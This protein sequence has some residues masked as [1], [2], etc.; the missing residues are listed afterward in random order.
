M[1]V[2]LTKKNTPMGE[3][4]G[5]VFRNT[6]LFEFT[7]QYQLGLPQELIELIRLADSLFVNLSFVNFAILPPRFKKTPYMQLFI[8]HD[9]LSKHS[10]FLKE[11]RKDPTL[12]LH[13]SIVENSIR[14]VEMWIKY[15]PEW[16]TPAP[17][18][19]AAICGHLDIVKRL[20]VASKHVWTPEAMNFAAMNGHLDV[21]MWLHN[22]KDGPGCTKTAMDGAA[23]Y[24]HLEVVQYLNENRSE[25]CT[26]NALSYAIFYGY[27]KVVE[28]LLSNGHS[29]VSGYLL[30]SQHHSAHYDKLFLHC[31]K[32]EK[33]YLG[34]IKSLH[35]HSNPKVY[36]KILFKAIK[37]D[38]VQTLQFIHEYRVYGI[39]KNVFDK[40][41]ESADKDA[42]RYALECI[43]SENNKPNLLLD[44]ANIAVNPWIPFDH[45]WF[46]EKEWNTTTAMDVAAA[47]GDLDSVILLHR[48]GIKC[49]T[50]EAMDKAAG[51]GRLDIVQ[52]LHK[53]RKESCSNDAMTF[54]A[55][56]GHLDVV[57][58]L[59][60]VRG[61]N[62]TKDG[63]CSAATNGDATMVSYLISITMSFE[64]NENFGFSGGRCIK[65]PGE[66]PIIYVTTGHPLHCAASRGHIKVVEIL[67]DYPATTF[68][69]N[70]AAHNGHLEMVDYLHTHRDEGCSVQAYEIAIQQNRLEIL[71]YLVTNKCSHEPIDY[72]ML[73]IEAAG[74]KNL[75]MFIFCMEQLQTNLSPLSKQL[76]MQKASTRGSLDMVKWLY[77]TK[78][79]KWTIKIR[80]AAQTQNHTIQLPMIL[81]FSASWSKQANERI[82]H[83]LYDIIHKHANV[84]CLF[85]SAELDQVRFTEHVE[86]IAGWSEVFPYNKHDELAAIYRYF[87]VDSIPQIRIIDKN[88]APIEP[89][90]LIQCSHEGIAILEQ[91]MAPNKSNVNTDVDE[92]L[93]HEMRRN[94]NIM[95][96]EGDF[97]GAAVIFSE[98]LAINPNCIKSNFN[99]AVILHTM[100]QTH[101]AVKLMFKVVENDPNDAT[102]HSVLRTIFFTIEP[103]LVLDGYTQIVKDHPNHL[104]AAH[105]LAALRGDAKT[106]ENEYVRAVF[107][108]LA[109]TFED[110][111]VNHLHYKVPWQLYEALQR[112]TPLESLNHKWRMIDLGCGTGLCGRI[113]N[114]HV[115]YII[116][117]DLSPVMVEKTRALGCY[118]EVIADDLLPVLQA[119]GDNSVDLILSADVWIYVGALELVFRACHRVLKSSGYLAFSIEEYTGFAK[120]TDM[121]QL[122]YQL[123]HSG[124]FQHSRSY[125]RR[126]ANEFGYV[127]QL[128]ESITVRQETSEPIP[129]VLYVLSI[130]S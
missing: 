21:V 4:A 10:L 57:K 95:Y 25:G 122:E 38:P 14:L 103:Q 23:T 35:S 52:W 1:V 39:T 55:A 29:E 129:G 124:R 67:H 49:C 45:E 34:V 24:G 2:I 7:C 84:T 58:W 46:Y 87:K 102:A 9:W 126:L 111:L 15:K 6:N 31:A 63:L 80:N 16:L 74:F 108:E 26:Q 90:D 79:F 101:L 119:Q 61:L 41:I 113:F 42:I 71:K 109:D 65:M 123:V 116:G 105:F 94:A 64:K 78:G 36:E 20:M 98:V 37:C 8:N 96:D 117:V 48:S 43:L 19:L 127:I 13:L 89:R 121:P 68:A 44:N 100:G 115:K 18:K 75:E 12:P 97:H 59:H 17:L 30:N 88:L 72:E 73:C 27:S 120:S 47:M 110:K 60:E 125:I 28:Y 40:I 93:L 53:Y 86:W 106:S 82:L 99:L 83:Q 33:D 81:I 130:L 112:T 91:I 51:I 107:D 85:L 56:R 32:E 77:E 11:Y 92:E 5:N 69:M 3:L 70:T 66:M 114:P 50:M 128:E 104:R 22:L 54:A 62:C 118:D 76:I